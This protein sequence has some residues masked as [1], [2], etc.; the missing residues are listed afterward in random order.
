[1]RLAP[2]ALAAL[3]ACWCAFAAEETPP[4]ATA[5][6]PAGTA[7]QKPIEAVAGQLPAVARF[8]FTGNDHFSSRSLLRDLEIR[9]G[10]PIPVKTFNADMA[11]II[12]RYEDDGYLLAQVQVPQEWLDGKPRQELLFT[13]TEG[14]RFTLKKLEI[15]GNTVFS[16]EELRALAAPE[17]DGYFTK[18]GFLDGAKHIQAHYGEVGRLT[19]A[20]E[21]QMGRR[22]AG[23]GAEVRY[24]IKE[25][26]PVTLQSVKLEWV[27]ERVTE[28]WLV[29]RELA[30]KLHEGMALT[31]EP[32]EEVIGRLRKKRWFK[33]VQY[34]VETGAAP[35]QAILVV[36]LEEGKTS[37]LILSGTGATYFG[38]SA[39]LQF[40]ESDFDITKPPSSWEEIEDWNMFRGRGELL[41][42]TALPGQ[43]LTTIGGS[44]VQPYTF[45][46]DNNLVLNAQYTWVSMP[47]WNEWQWQVRAGLTREIAEHWSA[48]FGPLLEGT[49]IWDLSNSNIPDY[50]EALGYAPGCGAWGQ[51]SYATTP[52]TPVV[53]RGVRAGLLVEPMY[54]DTSFVKTTLSA[55]RYF[56][57]HGE[58]LDAH[59]LEVSGQGGQVL[60]AAPFFDRFFCGGP[61][62]VRGFYVCGISPLY[63]GEPIGGYYFATGSAE[64]GFPLFHLYDEAYFRGALFVDAGDAETRLG[65]MD[66]IRVAPGFGLRVVL[67]KFRNV[68]AGVDFAWP[69]NSYPGDDK[70][71]V[72]FFIGMGL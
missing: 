1:V 56:P 46:T 31:L 10:K 9:T 45:G 25:G 12:A 20:V 40:R 60:G 28:E 53:N 72:S 11:H 44:F 24:V 21:P 63:D 4:A 6:Q 64:Y 66:R 22:P 67:P 7:A 13:I 5:P 39:A 62:S 43:R 27:N 34:R 23:N 2:T 48:G 17:R 41:T 57:V 19:T 65:D 14:P 42:L 29:R 35:D 58:G 52:D 71:V 15:V 30:R 51:L 49:E 37:G 26:P 55:S 47:D 54:E 61:G 33:S 3:L 18:G 69:V 70:Q 59:V 68:T 38:L 32:I 50:K 16:T 8:R 36:S